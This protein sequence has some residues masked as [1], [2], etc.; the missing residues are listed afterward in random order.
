LYG[1]LNTVL[2][3]TQRSATIFAIS[4][5]LLTTFF[6]VQNPFYQSFPP[7]F[8]GGITILLIFLL[9]GQAIAGF[10]GMSMMQIF[11]KPFFAVVI[12]LAII[13]IFLSSGGLGPVAFNAEIVAQSRAFLGLVVEFLVETGLIYFLA[14]IATYLILTR[15]PDD[16]DDDSIIQQLGEAFLRD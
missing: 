14:L 2:P 5:G 4:G 7:R 9:G 11:K 1:G 12:L 8:F 3:F 15:D 6:L 16:D 10:F 13:P